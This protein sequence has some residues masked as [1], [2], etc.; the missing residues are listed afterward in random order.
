MDAE[1][2]PMICNLA[3][4]GYANGKVVFEET[5]E[6]SMLHLNEVLPELAEKHAAALASHELQMIE[7]EFLDDP[8]VNKRFFRFGTDPSGMVCP[9]R[10]EL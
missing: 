7:L 1:I 5:R 9:I 6:I 8:D 10:F 3:I 4:R 2:N